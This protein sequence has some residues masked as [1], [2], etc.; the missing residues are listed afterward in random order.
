MFI[1]YILLY[2]QCLFILNVCSLFNFDDFK[3][4][5]DVASN[6][7]RTKTKLLQ[8]FTWN[9]PLADNKKYLY[10]ESPGHFVWD[11]KMKEWKPYHYCLWYPIR[12]W[13]VPFTSL[14]SMSKAL[15]LSFISLQLMVMPVLYSKKKLWN[16]RL[17][18]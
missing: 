13:K 5:E 18:Q 4:L 8:L 3:D 10:S 9:S 17:L 1:I 16:V 12:S 15:N 2:N 6:K 14:V 7:L 11:E